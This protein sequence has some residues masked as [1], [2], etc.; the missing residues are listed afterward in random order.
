M[1]FTQVVQNC[2][3]FSFKE[4]QNALFTFYVLDHEEP[5]GYMLPDFITR[6]DWQVPGFEINMTESF[7]RLNPATGPGETVEQACEKAFVALCKANV[8]RVS[9]LAKWVGLYD[10]DD[11]PEYH[12]ILGLPTGH[13]RLEVPSPL[14]GVFGIVTSGAHMTMYTFKDNNLHIWV[15]KRSP[16]VTYA[17]KYDQLAAGAVASEDGNNPIVTMAR[18]ALEEAC[19]EVDTETCKV[20]AGGSPLGT[21]CIGRLISFYDKKGAVA[22]SESGQLEPG[23]RHT[24]ELEVPEAFEPTPGEPHAIE[25][26]YLLTVEEVKDSLKAGNW[27]PNSAL[28]M[29]SFLEARGLL[30]NEGGYK[31]DVLNSVLK[32]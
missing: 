28:V 30:P 22:G 6:M 26:F 5:V 20:T 24:F 2:N 18:E 23:I 8:D 25:G 21:L 1:A 9:G 13:A 29:L 31:L 10:A 14:R 17:S 4:N 7:V 32:Y 16:H 11:S 19:L 27:K 15:A 3:K 12:P